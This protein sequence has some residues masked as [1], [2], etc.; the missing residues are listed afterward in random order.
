MIN[1]VYF[2]LGGVLDLDFS[3]TNKWNEFKT[4][5]GITANIDGGFE[6]LWDKF[7]YQVN[8]GW[9]VETLKPV[10]KQKFGINLPQE[11]SILI[12]GFVSRFEVNKSI[13]PVINSIQK[14]CK[15]GLLTNMYPGMYAAIKNRGILPEVN[16]DVIIDS[17]TVGLAKP[18]PDIYKLAE[19]KSGEKGNQILFV[20]NSQDNI[21]AAQKFG[22]RT[23]L[24]DPINP[25]DSSKKLLELYSTL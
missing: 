4:E 13:W 2:D 24:Y 23:F 6:K 10:L 3:K 19:E 8:T 12:D 20:E 11:Y 21:D 15:V 17:S 5:I 1:F 16:W 7:E 22:W 25:E 18:D 14:H 9:D